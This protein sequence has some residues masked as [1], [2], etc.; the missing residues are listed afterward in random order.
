MNCSNVCFQVF[1][2]WTDEMCLFM[3]VFTYIWISKM[4]L[5]YFWTQYLWFLSAI[6]SIYIPAYNPMDWNYFW[7]QCLWFLSY[8]KWKFESTLKIP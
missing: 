7:M 4:D 6:H 3:L 5:D 2:S 8:K 1:P